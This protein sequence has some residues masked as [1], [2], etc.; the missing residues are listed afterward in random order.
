MENK[1]NSRIYIVAGSLFVAIG[2]IVNPFVL[3]F[4]RGGAFSTSVLVVLL[5]ISLLMV[6]SGIVLI[7]KKNGFLSWAGKKYHDMAVIVF[8][9]IVLFLVINAVAAFFVKKTQE[10]KAD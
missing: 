1:N 9:M 3:Q 4:V 8:N 2:L 10:I 7:R 6:V 5:M